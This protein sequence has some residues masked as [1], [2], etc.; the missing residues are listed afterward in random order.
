M[1][2]IHQ[3]TQT[4]ATQLASRKRISVRVMAGVYLAILSTLSLQALATT[5]LYSVNGTGLYQLDTATSVST[6]VY[7]GAPF[8]LTGGNIPEALAQCRSGFLYFI[9]GAGN[10]TVYRYNPATP[11]T[12]PV[13][14][15]ATGAGIPAMNRAACRP[16]T[17]VL[18]AMGSNPVNLYTI[19]LTTG[20]ATTIGLSLPSIFSRPQSSNGDIAFTDAGTLYY[21]GRRLFSTATLWTIDLIA[22]SYTLIGNIT[23][24]PAGVNGLAF[25]GAG[26]MYLSVIGE[27]LLYTAPITGGAATPVGSAG[28]MPTM[29]DLSGIDVSAQITFAKTMTILCDPVNGTTNPKAIPGAIARWTIT[30]TNSAASPASTSLAQ[31][32]DALDLNSTFDQNLITGAGA[33]PATACASAT[34]TPESAAGRGFKLDVTGDTRPGPYPKFLTS[35]NADADGGAFSAGSVSLNFMQSLPTEGSYYASELKPGESVVVYF[36][37]TI[38]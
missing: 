18:Y 16:T 31:I 38:N 6:A 25:S 36:N 23:G 5:T 15:G 8:P 34:G 4:I 2:T 35:T 30:V 21:V 7:T 20:A 3:Q 28:A 27:T 22:N 17:D 33:P 37:V 14:L 24:T 10:G 9:T 11:A 12:A 13:A 1:R 26:T 19:N 32:T 29:T